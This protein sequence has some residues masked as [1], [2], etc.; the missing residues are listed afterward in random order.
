MN[1]AH[2]PLNASIL[3]SPLAGS[4]LL[5]STGLV[6]Q[7]HG[8]NISPGNQVT[9]R[10]PREVQA[11]WSMEM[12]STPAYPMAVRQQWC[13]GMCWRKQMVEAQPFFY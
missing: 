9:P 2:K 8:E 10:V 13:E 4:Q 7:T 3:S 5:P 11:F 1:G 12:P 6:T